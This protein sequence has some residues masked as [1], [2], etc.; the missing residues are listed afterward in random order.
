MGKGE[1][2]KKVGREDKHEREQ[3][4]GKRQCPHSSTQ[5]QQLHEEH[6]VQYCIPKKTSYLAP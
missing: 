6:I 4:R 3:G 1:E 5:R 2:E